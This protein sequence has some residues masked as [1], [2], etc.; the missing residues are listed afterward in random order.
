M[1]IVSQD[2]YKFILA[3]KELIRMCSY[4]EKALEWQSGNWSSS[5]CLANHPCDLT[6]VD[7]SKIIFKTK[8]ISFHKLY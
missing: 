6:R 7:S 4:L 8:E 1:E 5:S 3:S 2:S